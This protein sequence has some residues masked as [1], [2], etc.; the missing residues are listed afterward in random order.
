M[1]QSRWAPRPNEL[2]KT[3]PETDNLLDEVIQRATEVLPVLKGARVIERWAGVRPRAKSRAPLLGA[4]PDRPGHFVAN[5]GFKIGIGVA[6]KVAELM[7]DLVLDETDHIP[8]DF[9]LTG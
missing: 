9:R 2:S 6:P 4:W 1:A 5:G 3:R 8:D 7:C